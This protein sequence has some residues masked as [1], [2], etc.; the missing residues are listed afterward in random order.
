M[1]NTFHTE[2]VERLI[3]TGG[4]QIICGGNVN[5]ETKYVAPTVIFEPDKDSELM[6]DEIFGPVMPVYTYRDFSEAINFIN[7]KEKP[8]TVHYFGERGS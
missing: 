8:L 1:V 6:T 2:R 4:G 3:Q 5:R 7:T